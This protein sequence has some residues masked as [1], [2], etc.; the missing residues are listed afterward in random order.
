MTTIY[1]L[2]GHGGHLK[3]GL[4][5]ELR[6]RGYDVVGRQTVGDFRDLTFSEQIELVANDLR[7]LFWHREAKVIANSFGAYLFLHAQNLLPP[8]VG[9]VLLLSPIVGPFE[10]EE[11]MMIFEPPR[12]GQLQAMTQAGTYPVPCQCEIYVGELD[13]QS[14]PS[15]VT[16]LA[17]AWGHSVTVVPG[18]EHRLDKSYVSDLL[19]QW[20]ER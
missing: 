8:Y 11:R 4:G 17:N 2:P 13:W 20:L 9:R 1:Y 19:D 12:P 14:N 18:G 7:T 10:N 15:A 3:A 6:E 5:A 16:Q